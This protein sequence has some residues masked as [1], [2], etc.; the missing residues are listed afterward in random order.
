[1]GKRPWKT[2]PLPV[3]VAQL[4]SCSFCAVI[5]P[6]F[7]VGKIEPGGSI[8]ERKQDLLG[9]SLHADDAVYLQPLNCAISTYFRMT[10]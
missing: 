5:L 4:Q 3:V 2:M 7:S 8:A 6:T 10:L 9:T 1:M